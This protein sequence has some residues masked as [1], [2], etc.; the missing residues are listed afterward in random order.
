MWHTCVCVCLRAWKEGWHASTCVREAE[1]ESAL[2]RFG[3]DL[4][5]SYSHSWPWETRGKACLFARYTSA[6]TA[7]GGG[8]FM[9]GGVVRNSLPS[10][11]VSILGW[12]AAC[13]RYTL[14]SHK[15]RPSSWWFGGCRRGIF[16]QEP[17]T[18]FRQFCWRRS[19][20]VSCWPETNLGKSNMTKKCR[21]MSHEILEM[22]AFFFSSYFP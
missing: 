19:V 6:Y 17:G 15:R 21:F 7:E 18:E 4:Q 12:H 3:R 2:P 22:Q 20:K 8:G 11:A 1:S 13:H 16:P 14:H 5:R 10:A 9:E